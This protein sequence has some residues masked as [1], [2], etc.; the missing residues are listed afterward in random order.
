MS[1]PGLEYLELSRLSEEWASKY[2][3]IDQPE[4]VGTDDGYVRGYYF[5]YPKKDGER[6]L[7][8]IRIN[9]G[10]YHVFG[11]KL[12]DDIASASDVLK[13]RGYEETKPTVIEK[14]ANTKG[15]GYLESAIRRLK[16]T[17]SQPKT[18]LLC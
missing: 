13:E 18:C 16:R 17:K 14:D 7:T 9:N 8:Q 1:N 4:T 15:F 12:G 2:Y 3:N 5:R 11:I 6:R 10:D